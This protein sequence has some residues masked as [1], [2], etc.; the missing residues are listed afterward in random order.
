MYF[1]FLSLN[2]TAVALVKGL[3]DSFALYDGY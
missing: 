2:N 1:A 3:M